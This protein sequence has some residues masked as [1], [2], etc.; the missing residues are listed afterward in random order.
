MTTMPLFCGRT[1]ELFFTCHPVLSLSHI[2]TANP[3]DFSY[4]H[5]A[6]HS[7]MLIVA[8]MWEDDED[9]VLLEGLANTL[10]GVRTGIPITTICLLGQFLSYPI[11]SRRL[12]ATPRPPPIPLPP[13]ER[14][15]ARL[16]TPPFPRDF[17]ADIRGPL[18]WHSHSTMYWRIGAR[19]P[20]GLQDESFQAFIRVGCIAFA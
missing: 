6:K 1:S 18:G 15:K 7:S 16:L 12:R 2:R 5:D 8:R 13:S 19:T 10:N 17:E 3:S 14:T 11:H 20:P 4:K 9:D